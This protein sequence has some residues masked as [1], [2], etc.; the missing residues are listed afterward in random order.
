MGL[1]KKRS[2]FGEYIDK[3]KI[4]QKDI[5]EATGL[6]RN[7]IAWLCNEEKRSPYVETRQRIVSALR[8]LGHDVRADDFWDA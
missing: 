7:E 1:G 2:K 6:H 3:K 5:E 8:K 4:K